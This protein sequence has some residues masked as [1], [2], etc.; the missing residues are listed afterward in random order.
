MTDAP[1]RNRKIDFLRGISILLVLFHHF[2]IA[3]R[4]DDSFLSRVFGWEAVRAVARNGSYGV[5]IFFVIS[6]YLITGNAVRRWSELGH[7]DVKAFYGLRFA[8]IVPCLLL[9]LAVVNALAIAGIAIFQNYSPAG[10]PVSF[11]LVNLASLTFWMN[12]LIGTHGWTNYALGMLWSLSVE[13][14]FYLSFPLLCIVLRR[15]ARLVAFWLAC[16]VVGPAYRFLHQGDEGGYLYAYFACFDAIAIGCCA[17]LV[18]RRAVRCGRVW[19]MLAWP[20]A[21]VMMFVYLCWPIRESNVFGVTVMAFGTAVLLLAANDRP[22]GSTVRSA[23]ASTVLE[24]LGR[25]SYELYLFHL[26]VLGLL[27]TIFPPSGM[28]GDE[29]L[30]VLVGYLLLSACLSLCIARMYA[31]P[32][33]RIVRQWLIQMRSRPESEYHERNQP[34]VEHSRSRIE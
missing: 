33:G 30:A 2:N 8:R 9:L 26:I 7:V 29:K 17:A 15:E 27:R 6:G 18:A 13:E 24:W 10:T 20:T 1:T 14:V 19:S 23:R 12:V 4:L 31:E 5:T 32:S 16:I 22:H 11:W 25:L 28:A 34:D 21:V 3:Y